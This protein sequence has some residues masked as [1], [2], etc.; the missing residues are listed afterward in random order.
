MSCSTADYGC[1]G[2]WFTGSFN[3]WKTIGT[4]LLS[5]YP[6][7]TGSYNGVTGTCND[8][9]KPKQIKTQSPTAYTRITAGSYSAMKTALLNGPVNVAFAVSNDFYSYK[10]GIYTGA[11]T[12]GCATTAINHAMVAVGFG[13]LST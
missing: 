1:D 6:Y 4:V 3:Y 2:G 9:N 5:D 13:K 7:I 12:S 8:A 11:G 10:S